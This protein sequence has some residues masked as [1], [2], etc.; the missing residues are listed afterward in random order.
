MINEYGPDSSLLS[1]SRQQMING[2]WKDLEHRQYDQQGQLKEVKIMRYAA[3]KEN[4]CDFTPYIAC[5]RI[6]KKGKLNKEYFRWAACDECET[7]PCG[8]EKCWNSRGKL[9]YQR[10]YGKCRFNSVP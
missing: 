10:S 4:T 6:Y 2:C 9:M 1:T 8:V 7:N 5:Y 3:G